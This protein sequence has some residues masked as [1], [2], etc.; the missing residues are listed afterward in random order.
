MRH[1]DYVEWTVAH[2]GRAALSIGNEEA[3]TWLCNLFLGPLLEAAS[4]SVYF[5]TVTS[6]SVTL[7]DNKQKSISHAQK[8]QPA[9]WCEPT[10]ERNWKRQGV[11]CV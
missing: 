1:A 11:K 5:L 9:L 4:R 10:R 3:E 2:I 6:S 7:R 8:L